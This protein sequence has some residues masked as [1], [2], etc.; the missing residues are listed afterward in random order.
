MLVTL[1][2][3][4]ANSFKYRDSM[5]YE[6]IDGYWIQYCPVVSAQ[7]T[8]AAVFWPFVKVKLLLDSGADAK[9]VT[10]DH[11]AQLVLSVSDKS[12]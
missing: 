8:V 12:N 6:I 4:P 11:C 2:I 7:Y 3:V 10:G 9:V 5:R 1:F